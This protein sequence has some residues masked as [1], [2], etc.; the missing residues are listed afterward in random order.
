[1]IDILI[2]VT[3]GSLTGIVVGTAIDVTSRDGDGMWPNAWPILV[4][5]FAGV[6]GLT[7][8]LNWWLT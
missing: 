6:G 4:M 7:G 2:G 1:V 3:S 8:G 5:A